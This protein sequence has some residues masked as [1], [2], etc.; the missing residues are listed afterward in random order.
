MICSSLYLLFFMSVILLG[1]TDFSILNYRIDKFGSANMN[2]TSFF[3]TAVI[4]QRAALE[5]NRNNVGL[6]D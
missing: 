5:R 6:G 3:S 4:G 1:L 2:W